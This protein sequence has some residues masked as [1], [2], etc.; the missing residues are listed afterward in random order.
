MS[1]DATRRLFD[2]ALARHR[3]GDLPSATAFYRQA[4]A[5]S[6][7]FAPALRSLAH[8][9]H[10]LSLTDH[11]AH[12]AGYAASAAIDPAAHLL[13]GYAEI[14]RRRL[15]AAAHWLRRAVALDPAGFDAL[16]NMA[17]ALAPL[18]GPAA[19]A[20][21]AGR[22]LAVG[23]TSLQARLNRANAWLALG[24]WAEAWPE[25]E[26]RLALQRSYPHALRGRR[27]SGL[28][29]PEARLLI[30]DEIGYGDVFNYLRYVPLARASVGRVLLEVKP[31]LRRL[32]AG[33]SGVDRVIERGPEPVPPSDYDLHVPIESL[34]GIFGTT[35]ASVP[36]A[37]PPLTID[38]G[39]CDQW[40]RLLGR[41]ARP[42][43]GLV[44]AG[45]PTS[46]LD[47]ARS[48]R[49]ADLAPLAEI[50]DV[51][52]ISLQ[53]GPAASALSE[54]S[55][56]ASIVDLGGLLTD[57][58]DTA[59]VLAQLDAVVTVETA[60]AHLAGLL[61]RPTL[62]LLSRWPA[63]RWLLDRRD[64]PWYRSAMLFRQCRR[65]DWS[66]PVAALRDHLLS[67]SQVS[68]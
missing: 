3:A 19:T 57:F 48:C 16:N 51:D 1:A 23:P 5:L 14:G 43:I 30:H 60:V 36:P 13:R 4:L 9:C 67:R 68:Q 20:T 2:S 24:R 38:P 47:Q 6:P 62:I 29:A 39:L 25:H 54:E 40:R 55:F 49:L 42:R 65:G 37:G 34:P 15:P 11:A 22:A 35:V 45:S 58:A 12:L 28:S 59:A 56:G 63:W 21:W 64:T 32:L 17:V 31:G 10:D 18:D 8:A 27:W 50:P 66:A 44:W 46:G 33:A 61:G 41:R 52:W 26:L 53:K 7:A